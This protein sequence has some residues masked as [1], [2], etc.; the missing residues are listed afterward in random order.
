MRD[1]RYIV[2]HC[3]A[4]NQERTY[5]DILKEFK[6][7]GWRNPGYH[8]IIEADGALHK[9]L[10]DGEV[11]NGVKE[12]NANSMHVAYIG[13]IDSKGKPLDNRTPGQKATL[14]RVLEYLH[15]KYPSARILGHRDFS[16][17][18]NG[19]GIVDPWERVK[20]CPCFEVK[21][22]YKDLEP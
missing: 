16:P 15:G 10:E 18:K 2:V 13:G 14:R 19:N 20:A 3:T 8:Y 5:K 4:S 6:L 12:H 17:D 1:I 11:A 21:E 9:V 7:K 22:E